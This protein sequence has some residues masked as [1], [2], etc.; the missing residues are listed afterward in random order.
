MIGRLGLQPGSHPSLHAHGPSHPAHWS[1]VSSA[2][3]ESS[4][5]F[6]AVLRIK[7]NN[8]GRRNYFVNSKHSLNRRNLAR[9]GPFLLSLWDRWTRGTDH[10]KTVV[11]T[12]GAF[13][14]QTLSSAGRFSLKKMCSFKIK[15]HFMP[16][17]QGLEMPFFGNFDFWGCVLGHY[18][19][20][21]GAWDLIFVSQ[22]N[23]LVGK[24]TVLNVW[25]MA[26]RGCYTWSTQSSELVTDCCLW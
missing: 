23:L 11:C 26:C 8:E 6:R 21:S 10:C 16:H 22:M 1:S 18:F 12:W 15:S 20:Q 19:G 13:K 17:C 14:T 5:R 9:Y 4:Y 25:L 2:F 24:S 7:W 3:V